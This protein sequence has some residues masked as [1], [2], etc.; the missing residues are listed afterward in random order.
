[1]GVGAYACRRLG[2]TII[3]IIIDLEEWVA[4]AEGPLGGPAAERGTPHRASP[5]LGARVGAHRATP[6]FMGPLVAHSGDPETDEP[7]DGTRWSPRPLL[8]DCE[9]SPL[10]ED[11]DDPSDIALPQPDPL[12]AAALRAAWR[13]DLG[14]ELDEGQQRRLLALLAAHPDTFA[15]DLTELGR[16]SL[17][18]HEIDTG[19][20]PP[21]KQAAHSTRF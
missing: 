7:Q 11:P 1:M 14:E 5:P 6:R 17:V 3:I 20:A 21:Q 13:P 9:P 8:P 12:G 2:V 19:D 4:L 15:F 16:T 18:V 10:G